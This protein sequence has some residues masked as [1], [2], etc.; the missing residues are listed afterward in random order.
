LE[1][2]KEDKKPEVLALSIISLAALYLSYA[3]HSP[4]PVFGA[5][6]VVL[7]SYWRGRL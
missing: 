3:Y 6:L 5:L 7:I 1:N 2:R 4:A